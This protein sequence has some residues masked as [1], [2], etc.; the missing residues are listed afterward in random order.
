MLVHHSV[1]SPLPSP[2]SPNSRFSVCLPV[3]ICTLR[4]IE[5]Q[6]QVFQFCLRKQ[7]RLQR[8]AWQRA[9]LYTIMPTLLKRKKLYLTSQE[10]NLL[11]FMTYNNCKKSS[12]RR[13]ILAY[14]HVKKVY[15]IVVYTNEDNV[16]KK[17]KPA[18]NY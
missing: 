2:P 9:N 5:R 10:R 4:Y 18:I 6:C 13:K 16:V 7:G 17:K 3:A 11:G 15:D 14:L 12:N 8:I 1:P